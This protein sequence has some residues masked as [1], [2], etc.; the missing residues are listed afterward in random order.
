MHKSLTINLSS[1]ALFNNF[2]Q[3]LYQKTDSYQDCFDLENFTVGKW[4]NLEH[5]AG[6]RRSTRENVFD[7]QK[8]EICKEKSEIWLVLPCNYSLYSCCNFLLTNT[9]R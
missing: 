1:A 3:H 4:R 9:F 7:L 2:A 8:L 5:E 6:D